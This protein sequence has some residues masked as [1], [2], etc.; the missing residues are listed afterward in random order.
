[1]PQAVHPNSPPLRSPPLLTLSN[2]GNGL[3]MDSSLDRESVSQ[4]ATI[5]LQEGAAR[6]RPRISGL[7]QKTRQ[8][9]ATQPQR[10]GRS[11]SFAPGVAALRS[12]PPARPPALAR[13]HCSEHLWPDRREAAAPRNCLGSGGG[14]RIRTRGRAGSVPS[15]GQKLPEARPGLS[16][17]NLQLPRETPR[18]ATR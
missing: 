13:S 15:R 8:G 4:A 12:E 14:G 17:L 6:G 2:E 1:M 10:G 3:H 11:P 9:S 7:P 5:P 16:T 18:K